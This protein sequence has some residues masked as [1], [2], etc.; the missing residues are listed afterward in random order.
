[1]ILAALPLSF[2]AGLSQVT[3]AFAVGAHVVLMNY[4]LPGDVSEAVRASTA[5]PG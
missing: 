4:L 5:S 1:M 3:T 2:D